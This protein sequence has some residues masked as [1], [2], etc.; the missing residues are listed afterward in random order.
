M[1][2]SKMCARCCSLHFA[3]SVLPG[4]F[5]GLLGLLKTLEGGRGRQGQARG[6]LPNFCN[7]PSH[8]SA[9]KVSCQAISVPQTSMR[10]APAQPGASAK[11]GQVGKPGLLPVIVTQAERWARESCLALTTL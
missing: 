10:E 2:Q 7:S 6:G 9:F 11:K 3:V 1:I 4:I 8:Q 5:F